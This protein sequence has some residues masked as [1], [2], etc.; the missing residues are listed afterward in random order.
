M[1]HVYKKD[2]TPIRDV[3]DL[4]SKLFAEQ[5]ELLMEFSYFLPDAVQEQTRTAIQIMQM[6]RR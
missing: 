1:F 2:N 5:Y 3:F 4:V 6:G